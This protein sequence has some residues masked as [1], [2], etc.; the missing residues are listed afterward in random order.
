VQKLQ[1]KIS[2]F[3]NIVPLF[4]K[5]NDKERRNSGSKRYLNF[6][7]TGIYNPILMTMAAATIAPTM[8]KKSPQPLIPCAVF[9]NGCP[10]LGQ[11]TASADT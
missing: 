8:T 5:Y 11:A 10:H 6:L 2:N 9:L 1:S 7:P 4:I 3:K